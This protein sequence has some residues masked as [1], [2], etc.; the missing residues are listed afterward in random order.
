MLCDAL[1]ARTRSFVQPLG[2][3][4][5]PSDLFVKTERAYADAL[6]LARCLVVAAAT[7][8]EPR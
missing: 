5:S 8:L 2:E 4:M 6:K 1:L 3:G 7:P